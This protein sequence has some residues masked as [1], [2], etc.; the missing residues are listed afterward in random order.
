MYILPLLGI[1]DL[2]SCLYCVFNVRHEWVKSLGYGMYNANSSVAFM[3]ID[4][5]VLY[6]SI[7]SYVAYN[8]LNFA[9]KA[10]LLTPIDGLGVAP[11]VVAE[12]E[13]EQTYST[14][15]DAAAAV[16]LVDTKKKRNSGDL[17]SKST[18]VYVINCLNIAS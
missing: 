2:L 8:D 1:I 18:I 5:L 12:I 4:T 9:K 13:K 7:L 10:F 15:T 11:L 3:T 17:L 16:H 6:I 14:A